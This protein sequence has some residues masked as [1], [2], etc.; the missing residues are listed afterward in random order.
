MVLRQ[1][2]YGPQT[3]VLQCVGNVGACRREWRSVGAQIGSPDVIHPKQP[4]IR[5]QIEVSRLCCML[6]WNACQAMLKGHPSPSQELT[7]TGVAR[8]TL[9]RWAKTGRILRSAHGLYGLP[10]SAYDEHHSLVLAQGQMSN[11]VLCLHSALQFH[12]ITSQLPREVWMAME[13]GTHR[14]RVTGIKLRVCRFTK[15][16]YSLG[17]EV[18]QVQGGSLRVYG[19]T[20]TVVDCVPD[21]QQNW[22]GHRDRSTSGCPASEEDHDWRA[23]KHGSPTA[24]TH[25]PSPLSGNGGSFMNTAHSS[26]DRSQSTV[27]AYQ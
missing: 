16:A 19:M 21:A 14:P 8:S 27:Q 26:R 20:K 10:D 11:G 1:L 6:V 5:I 4:I 13:G 17:I 2:A 22:G 9:S 7:Q 24:L 15:E 25:D 18:H 12:G 23:G 3:C